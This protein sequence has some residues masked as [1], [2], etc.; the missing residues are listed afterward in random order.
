MGRAGVAEVADLE[1]GEAGVSLRLSREVFSG[2]PRPG[3]TAQRGWQLA[4]RAH[5]H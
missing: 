5:P 3:A 4:R 1:V 2:R